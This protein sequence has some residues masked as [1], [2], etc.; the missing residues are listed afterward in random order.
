MQYF[1]DRV[2]FMANCE[3]CMNYAYDDEYECYTCLMDLD[4]DEWYKFINERFK[5][6]PYFRRGD[7]Y[8]IVRK[9]I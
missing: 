7:E 4:E 6:C 1:S 9:Q 5:D 3:E 8:T 2:E